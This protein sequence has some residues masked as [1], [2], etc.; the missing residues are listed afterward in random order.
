M[1]RKNSAALERSSMETANAIASEAVGSIRTVQ[2]LGNTLFS[3]VSFS[4]VSWG[5]FP[6]TN[7]RHRCIF[8]IKNLL[9]YLAKLTLIV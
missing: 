1:A 5:S 9:A 3:F 8:G 6:D 4:S 2:S 7:E